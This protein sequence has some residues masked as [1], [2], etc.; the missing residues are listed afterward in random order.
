[1]REGTGRG[2]RNG[3]KRRP[4]RARKGDVEARVRMKEYRRRMEEAERA[5]WCG[6]GWGVGGWV[7]GV[8]VGERAHGKQSRAGCV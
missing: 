4:G 8:G 2:M 6:V 1:M 5:E 7:C 3:R